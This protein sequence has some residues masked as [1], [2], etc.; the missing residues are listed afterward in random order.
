MMKRHAPVL[1]TLLALLVTVA[2]AASAKDTWTQVRSKNFL[3]IGNASEKEIR[4][5]AT[6]L[7]QFRDVASR[8]LSGANFNSPVPT[9]VIVFKNGSSYKPYKPLYQG[10]PANV[11]GYFQRGRDVNYITLSLEQADDNPYD[12]IFHEY[13]HLLVA[14]NL[15]STPLWFNEGLSEYYSTFDVTDGDKKAWVGKPKGYHV[16]LLRETKLLPLQTFFSVDHDSPLYNE[17]SKQ[18]IFYAQSWALIHYLLRGNEGKRAPQLN[19][20]IDLVSGGAT[21]E[22]AFQ[23]AFQMDFVTLEKEL[24]QYVQ[25]DTYPVTIATFSRKLEFDTEMQSSPMTEA[26]A[27]ASLGDLLLHINRLEDA[28]ARLQQ[29]VTLDPKLSAAQSSLG[30]VRLRQR[31]FAEAKDALQKAVAAD[32]Q[33]YLAHYYYAYAISRMDAGEGQTIATYTPDELRE[34]RASLKKAIELK[35]DFPEPYHILAFVNLV[36]GE[37]VDESINMV[38]RA[39]TLSPGN[40]SYVFVLAQLYIQKREFEMAKRLLTPMTRSGNDPGLR[41]SAQAVLRSMANY[42][43]QLAQ[44]DEERKR[45]AEERST[46]SQEPQLK[47]RSETSAE[48]SSPKPFDPMAAI[49][50]VLRPVQPNEKRVQGVLVRIDCEMKGVVFIIRVGDALMKLQAPGFED[51]DISSYTPDVSGEISCGPRKLEQPVIVTY[52]PQAG[53][54]KGFEGQAVAIEFVPK[55]FVLKQ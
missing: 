23:Q 21:I 2:P 1:L 49:L 22:A 17:T 12:V 14:N 18:S 16:R 25:R 38:K 20:F 15:S 7:E 46:S 8:L 10:K 48:Q 39:L 4:E 26:E 30:I 52:R 50:E 35:P 51:M 6:K 43:E 53:A 32:P 28:E 11:S 3:L 45:R 5:V 40:Q 54:R 47:T 31:R 37:Q 55:D 29:A 33:N 41:A 44:Y 36:A 34:M 27:L 9:R 42:Q 24:K 19:Q 13:V